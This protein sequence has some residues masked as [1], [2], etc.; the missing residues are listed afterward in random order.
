MHLA[1]SPL[2]T[3]L[4]TALLVAGLC[5]CGP[6]LQPD[7]GDPPGNNTSTDPNLTHVDQGGGVFTT[8]VDATSKTEWIG[9]DLDQRKQVSA[10]EDTKWD[11]S[12][13]RFQIRTRGGVNG[14]GGVQVSAMAGADFA[15][16]AQA[17]AAGW[18]VDANDG[19]DANT[20][21]D[22]GF[23]VGDGWYAYD[24]VTHKLTPRPI[25]YVVRTDEGAYFKVQI[26]AY[27][28]AAGTPAMLQL[29]WAPVQAPGTGELQVDASASDAWVYV[30][31]GKGIVQVAEPANSQEWDLAFKRTQVRTNGGAS[32]PGLGGALITAHTDVAAVQHAPTVGYEPDAL[33]PVQGPPGSGSAPGNPVLNNWFDY[34]MTTHAVTPKARVFIVRTARGEYARL[35]I[36]TYAS[37][38]FT[39]L[40]SPVPRAA[41]VV[42]L[43]VDASDSQKF[44]GVKLGLGTV[45]AVAADAPASSWDL[46]FRRTWVQANSGTSGTGGVGVLRTES[47]TLAEVASAPE[48]TY[49]E[50]RMMPVAGP[51]GSGEASGNP[52]LNDWYDYDMATHVVTPKPQVFVV[53]A[54]GGAYA[55]LRIVSYANGVFTLEYS[56][57]GPGRASF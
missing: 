2:L 29:R 38:R 36:T 7:P 28:D 53:R 52:V 33:I 40:L 4:A 56:W 44:I 17:P 9:F 23:L 16:V 48:G 11:I 5:A 20:D 31:V 22:T 37:G 45:A 47:T 57:T 27:Y 41:E 3:R 15:Q 46:A 10:A 51:P 32:G 13:Q 34:D 14:S 50:D 49:S 42:R 8:T 24:A 6:D 25:V 1:S 35:R 55:R 19:D 30:Q 12:F 26:I 21:A 39:V 54:A 18:T 43:T